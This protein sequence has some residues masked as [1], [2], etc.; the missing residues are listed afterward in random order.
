MGRTRMAYGRISIENIARKYS[1]RK[2]TAGT[3]EIT[4]GRQGKRRCGKSE[5]RRRLENNIIK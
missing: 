1:T 3:L 5:T 4:M 2:K